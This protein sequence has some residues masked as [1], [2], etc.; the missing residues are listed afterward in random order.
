MTVG[1]LVNGHSQIFRN[2]LS[3]PESKQ[4]TLPIW[5]PYR[6]GVAAHLTKSLSVRLSHIFSFRQG[7]LYNCGKDGARTTLRTP[8]LCCLCRVTL[9][10]NMRFLRRVGSI[11]V[12]PVADPQRARRHDC[13]WHSFQT[14]PVRANVPSGRT[15]TKDV[16]VRP[17]RGSYT[18]PRQRDPSDVKPVRTR[19]LSVGRLRSRASGLLMSVFGTFGSSFSTL[20][21]VPHKAGPHG[22]T[23]TTAL[24]PSVSQRPTGLAGAATAIP[25]KADR[26]AATTP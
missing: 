26:Q 2:R 15:E 19:R 25:A 5:N 16:Y 12:G 17:L 9:S 14:Q 4:A 8:N 11:A 1:L 7:I 23:S 21:I 22:A 18:R 13:V 3:K 6:K 10:K 24:F 20:A